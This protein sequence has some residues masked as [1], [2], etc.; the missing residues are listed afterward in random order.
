MCGFTILI[1]RN[2]KKI[3]I[4]KKILNHRGPDYSKYI[5]NN[6]IN[7]RH[8]RLSIVDLSK[9]S[10]Q[11]VENEKY[12]FLYNGEIYNYENISKKILNTK[13]PSD[14]ILLY[15]L[16]NKYGNLKNISKFSGFYSYAF[17][18][19]K[20]NK[21]T[22]SR[23]SIGKKFLYYFQNKDLFILSSEEKGITP[24]IKKEIN[25]QSLLEYFY[26]KNLYYGKTFYKNINLIAPGSVCQFDLNKWK[27]KSNKN[28]NTF[29]RK[30]FFKRNIRDN[31]NFNK[32]ISNSIELRN[33]CD[34]DTQ[35]ALSSGLDSHL[36]LNKI[37]SNKR[38][39]NFSRSIGLGFGNY[40]NE[41]NATKKLIKGLS[42]NFKPINYKFNNFWKDLKKSIRFNDGPLEHPNNIGFN[43][44]SKEASKKGKI[45]ITGEGADDIF[46]GYEHYKKKSKNKT[47]AFRIFHPNKT[48]REIKKNENN[49][50]ILNN[51]KKKIRRDFFYKI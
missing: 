36:I 28:W 16:L 32:L 4:S 17:Y 38:I 18:D 3:N 39:K 10:N 9:K 11:P 22:F 41:N 35:L 7:F 19:K 8:W 51:I 34:V 47:F 23:D 44:L 2:K 37:I 15:N 21:I 43:I 24:F 14:T 12:I 29:Y 50:F 25:N 40:Q 13:A 26:F 33:K 1:K 27:V 31:F 49:R 46:F 30:K 20:N 42:T 48:I 6:G 5:Y 45:L